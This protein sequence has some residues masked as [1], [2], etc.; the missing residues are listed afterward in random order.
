[1]HFIW[2]PHKARANVAKHGVSFEEAVSVFYDPLAKI[3]SDPDHSDEENRFILIGHSRNGR[4]LFVVHV[5]RDR[6]ATVRII[7][8]RK[9]TKRETRDFEDLK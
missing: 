9:A 2:D 8:A 5:H 1:V 7:S 3:T 6:K 4:L